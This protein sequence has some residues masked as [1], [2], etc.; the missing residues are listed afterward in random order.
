MPDRFHHRIPTICRRQLSGKRAGLPAETDQL[1]GIPICRTKSGRMVCPRQRCRQ[2]FY[3]RKKR[4]QA[5]TDSS[6]K[7]PLYRGAERLRKNLSGRRTASGTFIA[8]SEIALRDVARKRFYPGSPLVYR[9]SLQ[10]QTDRPQPHRVRERI[11]PHIRLVQ[12]GIQRVSAQTHAPVRQNIT[13]H[14]SATIRLFL[15]N[16]RRPVSLN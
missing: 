7:D 13:A 8:Q 9:T 16:S 2:R 1:F 4:L 6:K 12:N 5:Q 15:R 3:L 11:Y 14:R 10:N